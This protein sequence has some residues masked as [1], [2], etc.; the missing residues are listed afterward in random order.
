MLG[1][2]ICADYL[3]P[4]RSFHD[5]A[6]LMGNYPSFKSLILEIIKRKIE[7]VIKDGKW[8]SPLTIDCYN[9]MVKHSNL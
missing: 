6:P 3:E 4:G 1:V 8:L 5:K 7:W 2:L 9:N